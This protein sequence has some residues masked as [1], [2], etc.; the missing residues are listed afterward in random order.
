MDSSIA[1]HLRQ[2]RRQ[3]SS[4]P[5]GYQPPYPA[6]SA[7]FDP[8][9]GQVVMACFGVQSRQAVGLAELGPI[10]TLFAADAGPRYWDS[11]HCVDAKGFAT[12]IA[13]AY[14]SD[15]AAFEQWRQASGFAA[16]WQDPARETGPLGWFMEVVCPTADRFETLFSALDAPEGVSHLAH[17]MSAPIVEHAYWGSARD[18]LPLAQVEALAGSTAPVVAEQLRPGRVRVPGRD[19]LCLIRSGQDWTGTTGRERE[20]YV[21]DVQ[22][23][24]RTGMDFLR[25]EGQAIGCLNCRL[26]QA[27]D[28]QTGA[29]V[30]KSF[31][32]VWFN[33][34][35]NLERWAKT[36]PTHLAIFGGFM[37]YVQ[38][39][40]FQVQLRLYHEVAVIPA[41][42]Q[43]FE[44]L[45]CHPDSGLLSR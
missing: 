12:C 43:Y 10:T 23:V 4:T 33:D 29:P 24:L 2:P 44:Y 8:L 34:L 32:L 21:N 35:A 31:G 3:A 19:N 38:A 14:W 16:W 28:S 36:H 25:D 17:G 42:A 13:I 26:M 37:Q 15:V 30:E 41:D 22:P 9:V 18:R 40:N 5:P 11:A 1:E 27:L 7:R 6:W 45:N 39:L 20:M